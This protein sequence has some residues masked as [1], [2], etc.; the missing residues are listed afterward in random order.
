MTGTRS[1]SQS[2]A[3][4]CCSA[5]LKLSSLGEN[6]SI[7]AFERRK[8][9][10][11]I[12]PA[13]LWWYLC[14]SQF[15]FL[16]GLE[17]EVKKVYLDV[18]IFSHPTSTYRQRLICNMVSFKHQNYTLT[19]QYLE[20]T[21]KRGYFWLINSRLEGEKNGNCFDMN[22]LTK[23]NSSNKNLRTRTSRSFTISTVLYQGFL[24]K[25]SVSI[26]IKREL[27]QLL[28]EQRQANFKRYRLKVEKP[29]LINL[30]LNYSIHI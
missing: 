30:S 17:A 27:P 3:A 22:L 4:R 19:K 23:I 21:W 25:R 20:Y 15:N 18:L 6:V 10:I 7:F 5:V 14:L 28:K 8:V 29:L 1:N 13:S 26:T 9:Y 12:F 2:S 11:Q 16:A 24:T